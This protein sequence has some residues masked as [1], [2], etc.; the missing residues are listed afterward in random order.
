M[1]LQNLDKILDKYE[2][3]LGSTN[4]EQFELLKVLPFYDCPLADAS[5]KYYRNT[6]NHAIDLPQKMG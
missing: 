3:Q 2:L 4:T 1:T 5:V 6:F